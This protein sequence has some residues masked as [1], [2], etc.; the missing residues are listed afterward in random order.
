MASFVLVHGAWHGGWCWARLARLLRAAGH[1]VFTPT[2][3]G[4][5]ERA[6]HPATPVTLA[7]HIT[8]IADLLRWEN[9]SNVVLLGHSYGGAVITGAAAREPARIGTLVYLDAF[10]P[11]PGQAMW[12]LMNETTRARLAGGVAANGAWVVPLSAEHFNVNEADRAWVDSQ[13][14]PHP[15]GCFLQA[16]PESGISLVA[17]RHYIFAT[18][19]ERTP[20]RPFRDACAQDPAWRVDDIAAGHDAMLDNPADLAAILLKDR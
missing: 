4:L 17:H 9:L 8:D 2:L 1:D 18:G 19:Y 5:A 10:I 14:T 15:I 7:T 3:T 6:H 20:F 16:L 13:C 12:D 11:R